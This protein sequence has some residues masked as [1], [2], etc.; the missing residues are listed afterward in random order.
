MAKSWKV[1]CLAH[2]GK[3]KVLLLHHGL[4]H[5][6]LIWFLGERNFHIFYQ[7]LQGGSSELLEIL[8]LE[9]DPSAYFYLN[10]VQIIEGFYVKE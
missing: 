7:L 9:R 6:N 4:A 5:L 1:Y 2:L 3:L 10:Q 8:D